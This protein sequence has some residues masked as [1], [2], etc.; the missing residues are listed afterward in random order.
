M[1]SAYLV[2]IARRYP[3]CGDVVMQRRFCL[4]REPSD[5]G[6]ETAVLHGNAPFRLQEP[7]DLPAVEEVALY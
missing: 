2:T 4:G 1:Q 7:T 6:G 3:R 5:T